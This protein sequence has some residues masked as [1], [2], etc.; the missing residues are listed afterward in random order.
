MIDL[1]SSNVD[2]HRWRFE[3]VHSCPD[4]FD[5]DEINDYSLLGLFNDSFESSQ[6]KFIGFSS[7]PSFRVYLLA[8]FYSS[9]LLIVIRDGRGCLTQWKNLSSVTVQSDPKL[10]ED[11][12]TML[13]GQLT[14]NPLIDLLNNRNPNQVG[15]VITSLTQQINQLDDV[16]VLSSLSIR[17]FDDPASILH[18]I[19]S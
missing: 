10:F 4:W 16:I 2:V 6:R 19:P 8:G 1:L 3:V 13:N 7:D 9:Q 15:Q 14:L 11:F 17:V 18:V 12:M 5:E